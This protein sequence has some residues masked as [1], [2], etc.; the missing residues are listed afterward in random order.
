MRPIAEAKA[1]E[2]LYVDN[3]ILIDD[4]LGRTDE[5]NA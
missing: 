1:I 5:R 4:S 3:F 2:R